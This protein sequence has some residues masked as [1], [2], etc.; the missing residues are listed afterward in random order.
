MSRLAIDQVSSVSIAEL[1]CIDFTLSATVDVGG[2]IELGIN[3]T[4]LDKSTVIWR[5]LAMPP[6]LLSTSV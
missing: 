3:D 6:L 4:L 2:V 1:I 5:L